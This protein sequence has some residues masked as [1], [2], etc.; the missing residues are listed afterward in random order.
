MAHAQ[1]LQC[2]VDKKDRL[3]DPLNDSEINISLIKTSRSELDVK[4]S[5]E[6]CSL[7]INRE[8]KFCR[9]FTLVYGREKYFF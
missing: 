5:S 2:F 3:R 9:L 1:K 4:F 6:L 7:K 8:A